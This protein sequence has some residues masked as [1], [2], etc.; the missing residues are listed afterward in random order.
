[1][2]RME[3]QRRGKLSYQEFFINIA[4]G[5]SLAAL[6]FP[7]LESDPR[8][9]V[10]IEYAQ[11]FV[12]AFDKAFLGDPNASVGFLVALPREQKEVLYTVFIKG[13]CSS[14]TVFQ[15][16]EA[17]FAVPSLLPSGVGQR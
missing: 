11:E 17:I 1:M 12:Q 8:G 6:V 14:G 13:G 4:H 7:L 2:I 3:K 15:S 16:P 5:S 10:S 9:N